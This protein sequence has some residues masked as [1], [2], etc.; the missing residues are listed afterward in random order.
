M[1]LTSVF[2]YL[3][4]QCAA[5]IRGALRTPKRFLGLAG[6]MLV[7][8]FTFFLLWVV[9]F[10]RFN[11]LRGW[12]LHDMATLVGIAD[13]VWGLA[14]TLTYNARQLVTMFQDGTLDTYLVRPQPILPSLLVG[15]I[16]APNFGDF[17]SPF[18]YWFVFGSNSVH[19]LP[20]LMLVTFLG[21]VI[22][23]SA[24]ICFQ[25]LV[26]WLRGTQTTGDQFTYMM[27]TTATLPQ[28]GYG[29][30]GKIAM[31]TIMPAGFIGMAPVSILRG[32]ASELL[33]PA[34]IAAALLYATLAHFAFQAMLKRYTSATRV[35]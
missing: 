25:M 6:A 13:G 16:N 8:D 14:F 11:D 4:A 3:Y 10:A 30:W 33:L 21:A 29:R 24:V 17:L 28:Q 5:N 27:I 1:P 19:D 31:F 23:A 34:L 20:L 15:R 7:N 32:E 2:A 26:V 9:Y 35:G 12:T 18:V 22:M